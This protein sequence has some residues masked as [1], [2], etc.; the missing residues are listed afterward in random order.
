MHTDRKKRVTLLFASSKL[1]D[2]EHKDD[3][4]DEVTNEHGIE[5][6]GL[7]HTMSSIKYDFKQSKKKNNRRRAIDK[8]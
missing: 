6:K 5:E 2:E 8:N 3:V 4:V 1:F 7:G